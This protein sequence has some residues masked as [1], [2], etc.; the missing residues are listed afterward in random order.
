M[1]KTYAR[2]GHAAYGLNGGGCIPTTTHATLQDSNLNALL[3]IDDAGCNGKGIKLGNIIGTQTSSAAALIY[4][5]ARLSSS[6]NTM[7]K[8]LGAYWLAV[9]F[10]ALGVVNQ[11]RRGVQSGFIALATQ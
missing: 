6:G 3:G 9:N 8:I 1:I 11:L 10:H 2:N 7:P 5:L 4:A